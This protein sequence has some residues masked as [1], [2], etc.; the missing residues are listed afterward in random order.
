MSQNLVCMNCG[1]AIE[2]VEWFEDVSGI[3]DDFTD[4]VIFQD[5]EDLCNCTIE[6]D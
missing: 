2:P 1:L 5:D 3:G 6:K 4:I